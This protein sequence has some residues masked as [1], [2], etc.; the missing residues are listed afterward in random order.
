MDPNVRLQLYFRCPQFRTVHRSRTL[1]IRDLKVIPENF[2]IDGTIYRVGVITQYTNKRNPSWVTV[3]NFR[4]GLQGD[5]DVYGLPIETQN[6]TGNMPDDNKEVAIPQRQIKIF[7][8]ILQNKEL[9]SD[10]IKSIQKVIEV[11]QWEVERLQMRINKS[12]PPN[13]NIQVRNLQIGGDSYASNLVDVIENGFER[14]SVLFSSFPLFLYAPQGDIVKPL[15]SIREGCLEVG[16]LKVTGNVTNAVTSLQ[17]VLSALPLKQL[18]TVHQPFP[19]DPIIRTAQ[20]V[21][22]VNQL[23]F[24]VLFTVQITKNV[25]KR[26]AGDCKFL[27]SLYGHGGQSSSEPCHLCFP[28][29]S[30]HG[31]KKALI[32]SFEFDKYVGRR[33]LSDYRASLVDVPLKNSAIPPMHI[34]QGLTQK[35]GID[36]FLSKCNRL[37]YINLQGLD[38]DEEADVDFPDS[39]AGQ[40]KMLKNLENE[41]NHYLEANFCPV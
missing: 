14:P 8:E 33:S 37:N 20:L 31:S 32:E 15:L 40:K 18:R 4:G 6:E 38:E 11:A 2:E 24:T 1:R 7:E 9:G 19:D 28:S 36:H 25:Q 16:V 23:P 3:R 12:P 35:Y 13:G 10:Y 29:Y 34:F 41:E 26:V 17:K 22:I 39:L 5:F 30:T 27:S 21:M